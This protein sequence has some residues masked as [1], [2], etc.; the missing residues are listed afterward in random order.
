MLRNKGIGIQNRIIQMLE[1]MPGGEY[2]FE[3]SVILRNAMLISSILTNSEVWYGVTKSDIEQLE[4]I[5]EMWMRNLFECSRNVPKDLLY[6]ELGLTPISYIIKGRKQMFLHHILQQKEISLLYQ[7]FMAQMK[8]PSHNDWV[9]SVLEEMIELEIDLEIEDI[10]YMK[11]EKFKALVKEKV[12]KKA[13]QYLLEKKASRK[14]ERAKGK[15]LE[16]NELILSEYLSSNENNLSIDERKWLL[17]CRIEDI[18]LNTNR[19]WN[20]EE[21]SCMNCPSTVM[22]QRHLLECKY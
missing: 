2:H 3:I 13:F 4:Q 8:T 10:K 20:N 17:K 6:L 12:Q 11:K 5:D 22:N 14:S 9:S 18:D 21:S 15:Y 19:K 7:F 1:K 16:Y